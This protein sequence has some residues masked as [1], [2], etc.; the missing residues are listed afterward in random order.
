MN[1]NKKMIA[2]VLTVLVFLTIVS[3][4]NGITARDGVFAGTEMSASIDSAV[5][6]LFSQEQTCPFVHGTIQLLFAAAADSARHSG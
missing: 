4:A 3:F 5:Y 1:T 2:R 6:S